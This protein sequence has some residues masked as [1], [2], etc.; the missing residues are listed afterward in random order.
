MTLNEELE[1]FKED[2]QQALMKLLEGGER[3]PFTQEGAD[4]LLAKV[5]ECFP[6]IQHPEYEILFKE[7]TPKERMEGKCTIFLV[8]KP[9]T[10][11]IE[12]DVE[13]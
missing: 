5:K 7:Q 3:I 13:L 11:T 4:K 8:E 9:K 12:F 2:L 6:E 10:I 1:K